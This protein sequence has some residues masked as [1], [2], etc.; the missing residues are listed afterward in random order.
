MSIRPQ[1]LYDTFK[2]TDHGTTW[3]IPGPL[4][5]DL[6]AGLL[7]GFKVAFDDMINRGLTEASFKSIHILKDFEYDVTVYL[8]IDLA[9]EAGDFYDAIHDYRDYIGRIPAILN[10]A[11]RYPKRFNWW[12]GRPRNPEYTLYSFISSE[13]IQ[14]FISICDA[15]G[16]DFRDYIYGLPFKYNP[17]TK[18]RL[19]YR[20][21]GYDIAPIQP[22]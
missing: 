13:F 17:R 5:G 1:L 8:D 22:L 21:E 9:K 20:I 7:V 3:S 12:I 11:P 6:A 4:S 2:F 15:F 14:G 19:Y 18:E 16:V 10:V